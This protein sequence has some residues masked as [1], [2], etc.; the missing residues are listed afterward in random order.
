MKIKVDFESRIMEITF[1]DGRT[2]SVKL[3]LIKQF[4]LANLFCTATWMVSDSKELFI[5]EL[6]DAIDS[7]E[8][9]EQANVDMSKSNKNE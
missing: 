8:E 6:Q 7:V 1:S 9:T 4:L 2:V 3:N 5:K